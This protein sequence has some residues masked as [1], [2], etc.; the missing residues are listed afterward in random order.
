MTPELRRKIENLHGPILVLGASGFVGANLLRMLLAARADAYGT[1]SR[2]PAWRLEGLPPENVIAT[3]LLVEANVCKLLDHVGPLTVFNCAAYGAYSFE[4][5]TGL[6]YRTNLNITVTFL[7]KLAERGLHAYVHAGT[8]SEYGDESAAPLEA[9]AP[10]PNSHYAASKAAAAGVIHFMGKTR[11]LPCA[12]LRFYS[13]YGPFEDPSRLVP[14]V[15]AHGFEGELPPFVDPQISRDFVYIDDA[16]EAFVDAARRLEAGG[17]GESYNIGT[18]RCTTI[19]D[20][21]EIAKRLFDIDREPRFTMPRRDWDTRDW[22]A[23]ASKARAELGWEAHTSFVEGLRKTADWYRALEDPQAYL[24]SSKKFELDTRRSVS[25]I[26]A[27]YR[28]ERAIPIMYER[29]TEVF[30]GLGIDYEII[31]VNDCSPDDSEEVIRNLSAEDRHV[32]GI[33]HSRNFGSQAAFRS[34]ME[35][36]SKNACVL[37]DGDLQDP[38]ELIAEFVDK[39]REGFDVVYGRRV[40]RQAPRSMQ[41]AYKLF[42]RIFDL[43]SYLQIPHDAGDFSLLDKRVTRELMRFPER[44]LFLRGVRAFVGFKQTG[45]DYVRP[46]RMF[47]TS[48]NSW[49]KNLGWAKK[50]ILSFSNAPLNFLSAFGVVSFGVVVLLGIIQAVAKLLFPDL[51]PRGITTL[52]LIVM[53]F[54]AV[55]L[56]SL[57]LLGEYIAKIF[58]EVKQR[59]HFVRRSIIQDGEVREASEQVLHRAREETPR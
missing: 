19:G 47:G 22:Y 14:T 8:S 29:L 6:I 44:D 33:S 4:R 45:V 39:W 28:D 24:A 15:V 49:L 50:G 3:D 31:F 54:G 48:T 42:Y 52:M 13:A 5:D 59:P 23:D 34:G 2:S 1:A 18:G 20:V 7:E 16:C 55:N 53:A 43:F 56:L 32:I 25:A 11:G 30:E 26:I 12:N 41:L 9:A 27:C 36:V 40:K 10:T 57:G 21:A 58:E 46:E 38:P 35:V 51:A 17:S 37:L